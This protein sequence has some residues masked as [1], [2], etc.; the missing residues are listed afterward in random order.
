[1]KNL[2]FAVVLSLICIRA[3]A[4]DSSVTAPAVEEEVHQHRTLK[5]FNFFLN[6][7]PAPLLGGGAGG[8]VEFNRL[9][10]LTLTFALE[11]EMKTNNAFGDFEQDETQ[12]TNDNRFVGVRLYSKHDASGFYAGTGYKWGEVETVKRPPLFSGV[13]TRKE[14]KFSGIYG[15]AG[16]RFMYASRRI[17][18]IVELGLS[19][20]PGEVKRAV[21]IPENQGLLGPTQA[22]LETDVDYGVFPEARFGVNF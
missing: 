6:A 19:Y 9:A 15:Q 12:T 14:D 20:E 1:M 16:W 10:P 22:H 4:Q 21:Y 5:D 3:W 8:M 18:W 13:E 17:S 2:I 11:R 7:I